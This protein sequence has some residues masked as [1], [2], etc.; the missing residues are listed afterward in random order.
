MNAIKNVPGMRR[1]ERI[2]FIGIG[3]AG[4]CGIAEVLV[5][6]KYRVSGSDLNASKNTA[7]LQSL[8]AEIEIGHKE[9]NVI[10]ADVVVVSTAIDES[11]PEIQW[12][13]EHRVPI[14]QRAEMLAELMRYRHGIAVAGTHGKTTTTSMIASILGSA[15]LDPTFIIGGLVNNFGSNARLGESGYLIA[16]ADES[17]ASFLHLQPMVSVIT[18]IEEDHMATYDGD[19]NKLKQTFIEFIHN[20]PFYGVVV[21]CVDDGVIRELM[22]RMGRATISYGFAE[23]ADFRISDVRVNGMQSTFTV[24]YG[25]NQSVE[26]ILNMPGVH[27]VLNA[28]A[29]V[30]VCVDEGIDV[31]FI[32][33]GLSNFNGVGRRFQVYGDY[34]VAEGQARLVDDYGHHPTEVAAT[35]AAARSSHPDHRILMI[36]QP[37]R[38]SRLKDLYDDFVDALDAVDVLIVLD[39]YSAGESAIV[40][41]DSRSLCGSIRQRGKLDPVHVKTIEQVPEV[42]SCFVK[43]NDLVITQGAGNV[44]ALA[45]ML[46]KR[47]LV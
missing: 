6:Q 5:N 40:G 26:L 15:D 13:R 20:L 41:A 32:Q 25:D 28:T 10:G 23:D 38:Y 1:I 29:A 39:V 46:S 18:N 31:A 30:A 17:D 36:F 4:M 22:P 43:A 9:E 45:E 34:P 7:R 11:N 21:V 47:G 14:V 33:H 24:N 2:H 44:G 12:A 3:G 37:H 27:N 35:I 16:E 42:L 19:F 8:G